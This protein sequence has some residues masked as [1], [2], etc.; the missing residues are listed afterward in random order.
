MEIKT[1]D[2]IKY[3]YMLTIFEILTYMYIIEMHTRTHTHAHTHIT[4]NSIFVNSGLL[5]YHIKYFP[6]GNRIEYM[7]ER[8]ID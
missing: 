4:N 8:R 3:A 6:H 2:I 7:I 5:K 1:R